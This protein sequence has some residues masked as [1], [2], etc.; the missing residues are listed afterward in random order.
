MTGDDLHEQRARSWL[1]QY[2]RADPPARRKMVRDLALPIKRGFSIAWGPAF[3]RRYDDH[4]WAE[5]LAE[6]L[7]NLPEL[8]LADDLQNH[9]DE[10]VRDIDKLLGARARRVAVLTLALLAQE[11]PDGTSP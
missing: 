5:A 11:A 3:E 9:R 2:V 1:G 8:Q 7:R 4:A 10:V 6:L